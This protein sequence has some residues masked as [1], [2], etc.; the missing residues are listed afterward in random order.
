MATKKMK[1]AEI[2]ALIHQHLKRIEATP[3][4]S[5]PKPKR[6]LH[7][8]WLSSAHASGRFVYVTY[9]HYQGASHLTRDEAII[10]LAWLDKG[11]VGKHWEALEA[12]E[13]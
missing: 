11:Y 3:K 10:Y 9:V 6:H 13:K 4:L 2:A 1:L 7:P 12:K 5:K 8:Y